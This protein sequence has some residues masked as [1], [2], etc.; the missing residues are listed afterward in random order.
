MVH[1]VF[2]FERFTKNRIVYTVLKLIQKKKIKNLISFRKGAWQ[3][4]RGITAGERKGKNILN[5]YIY[6]FANC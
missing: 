1:F 3:I 4:A 6:T 5:I 2:F